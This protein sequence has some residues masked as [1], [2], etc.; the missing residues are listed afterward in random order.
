MIIYKSTVE[1]FKD[2]CF[3]RSISEVVEQAFVKSTG[4]RVSSA[5]LNAWGSSLQQI[6]IALNRSEVPG[7][8]GVAIEYTIP[9]SSK[10]VDFILTGYNES[11]KP[12]MVIVELKQWSEAKLTQK[13][14][15]VVARRGGGAE[16]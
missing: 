16:T 10:R 13:D 15:I 14:G 3:S 9:Q 8:S 6:A 5:E 7:D 1:G 2:T 4:H 12:T 11:R